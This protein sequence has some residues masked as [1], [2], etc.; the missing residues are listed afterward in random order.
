MVTK[1]V[2]FKGYNDKY[3]KIG[4]GTQEKKTSQ[5]YLDMSILI[6][7]HDKVSFCWIT[8]LIS[9]V[10]A[11]TSYVPIILGVKNFR[12]KSLNTKIAI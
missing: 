12:V 10:V 5:L 3:D 6:Q 11:F 4:K 2:L 9:W 1:H 7:T 8:L